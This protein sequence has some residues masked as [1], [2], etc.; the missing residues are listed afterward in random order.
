MIPAPMQENSIPRMRADGGPGP[1]YGYSDDEAL[2]KHS[3][4]C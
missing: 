3:N 1:P 2:D 4:R